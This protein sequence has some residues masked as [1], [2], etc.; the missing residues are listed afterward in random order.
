MGEFDSKDLMG[1][2]SSLEIWM[3]L[4]VTKDKIERNFLEIVIVILNTILLI[5]NYKIIIFITLFYIISLIKV[6]ST[7]LKI[8]I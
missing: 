7:N 8:L 6:E 1:I 3:K 4:K 2:K 5:K